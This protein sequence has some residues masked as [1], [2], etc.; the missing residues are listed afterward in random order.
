M[1]VKTF[2]GPKLYH[3]RLRAQLTQDDL[4]YALR[5]KTSAKTGGRSVR[6]WET[7]ETTPHSALIPAIASALNIAVDELYGDGEDDEEEDPT[8]LLRDIQHLPVDLRRRI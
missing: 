5:Q 8:V 2:S 7:G 4:A 6:R 3:A 1:K